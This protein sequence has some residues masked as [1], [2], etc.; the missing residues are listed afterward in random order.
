VT[1]TATADHRRRPGSETP[2]SDND[3]R[4]SSGVRIGWST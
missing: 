4:A 3:T 1:A 2:K